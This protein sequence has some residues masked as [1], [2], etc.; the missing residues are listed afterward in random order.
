MNERECSPPSE[1]ALLHIL[2]R[3]P[4]WRSLC[5]YKLCICKEDSW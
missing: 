4:L 5:K 2:W 1:D 3:F